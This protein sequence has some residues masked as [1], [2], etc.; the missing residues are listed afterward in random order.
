MGYDRNTLLKSD[1]P[2][3]KEEFSTGPNTE[4]RKEM[5]LRLR[6]D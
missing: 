3:Q 2:M 1:Q 5:D 6:T 4:R